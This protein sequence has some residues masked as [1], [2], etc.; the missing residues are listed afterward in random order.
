MIE[1][2]Y[3]TRKKSG[4]YASKYYDPD[5]THEYYM[6]HR[7]LKGRTKKGT[8]KAGSSKQSA[9][10]K[11]IV[12]DAKE[13]TDENIKK[14]RETVSEWIDKQKERLKDPNLKAE[15]KK[16]I[17]D[18]IRAVR[19]EMQV[20]IK[21]AR[22]IYAKFKEAAKNHTLSKLDKELKEEEEKKGEKK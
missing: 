5:K 22:E 17:R 8:T 1:E 18:N 2:R 16:R 10:E 13:K 20:Q 6:K 3:R 12:K 7:K 15:E 9:A 14:L 4:T 11:Q 19:K 21:K